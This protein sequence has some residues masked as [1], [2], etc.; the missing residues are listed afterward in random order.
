VIE[1]VIGKRYTRFGLGKINFL[2]IDK[3]Y[4]RK[5]RG[6]EVFTVGNVDEIRNDREKEKG[7]PEA[8]PSHCSTNWVS[9]FR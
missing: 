6:R 8:D 5:M 3:N 9:V 7:N 1:S 2:S 4:L